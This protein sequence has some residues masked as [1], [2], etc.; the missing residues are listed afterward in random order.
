[1]L[2][3]LFRGSLLEE[4]QQ[5]QVEEMQLVE[6]VKQVVEVGEV[7]QQPKL[8]VEEMGWISPAEAEGIV[9]PKKEEEEI[10][11]FEV[12]DQNNLE[13]LN[14]EQQDTLQNALRRTGLT[15]TPSPWRTHSPLKT[16]LSPQPPPQQPPRTFSMLAPPRTMTPTGCQKK[17]SSSP[18]PPGQEGHH[19][20]GNHPSDLFRRRP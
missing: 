9:Q 2:D 14:P 13:L 18:A 19:V 1:M 16:L 11:T 8:E 5:P 6:Q 3:Q 20:R 17:N 4:E 7:H 15:S 10:Y 12:D